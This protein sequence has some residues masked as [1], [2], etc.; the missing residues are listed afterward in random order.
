MEQKGD[1]MLDH[2]NKKAIIWALTPM[3]YAQVLSLLAP[4]INGLGY[5]LVS[6]IQPERP[7]D[8]NWEV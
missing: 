5:E 8:V 2:D 4:N 7:T 1:F 3:E 6:Y